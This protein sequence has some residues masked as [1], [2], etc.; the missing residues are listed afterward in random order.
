ML[1]VLTPDSSLSENFCVTMPGKGIDVWKAFGVEFFITMGLT[2]ICCGVWDPRNAKH[3]GMFNSKLINGYIKRFSI[4]R[5]CT[6]K[7]WSCNHNACLS[8]GKLIKISAF[9]VLN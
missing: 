3:H 1:R 7:I 5:Q 2:L 8:W 9:L 4:Y 6:F